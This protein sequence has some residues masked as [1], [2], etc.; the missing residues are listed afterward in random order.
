MTIDI[1]IHYV[2]HMFP[3][4]ASCTTVDRHTVDDRTKKNYHS[5][6][7]P[8]SLGCMLISRG[9]HAVLD[10]CRP[11]SCPVWLRCTHVP[12]VPSRREWDNAIFVRIDS[13]LTQV[14]IA[15][16]QCVRKFRD[17]RARVDRR[18]RA[19]A[20][21]RQ[22]GIANTGCGCCGFRWSASFLRACCCRCSC[23]RCRCSC[24][25]RCCCWT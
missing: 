15:T 14:D 6:R 10:N 1:R 5:L 25:R 4:F 16:V 3:R 13:R 19:R 8:D 23:C 18:C 17:L 22:R 21:G 24:C 20:T 9:Q 12:F 11:C 7:F 2:V